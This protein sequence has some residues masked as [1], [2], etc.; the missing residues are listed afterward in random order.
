LHPDLAYNVVML[1]VGAFLVRRFLEQPRRLPWAW[2]AVA[3][4]FGFAAAW[5][6][7]HGLFHLLRLWAELTFV[8]LPAQLTVG[9][10]LARRSRPRQATV[11]LVLAGIV[12]LGGLDAL[13][14][15]P[16]SLRIT[17]IELTS[18]KI[19][20]P[21]RIVVLAD[22]QTDHVGEYE[23]RAIERGFG[24]DPDLVLMPGDYLQVYGP[25]RV[26][27]AT[28]FREMLAELQPSAPLGIWAVGGNVDP[29]D[30][31]TLFEGTEVKTLPVTHTVRVN[32]WLT[33]TGLSLED[34]VNPRLGIPGRRS[35]LHVVFGHAPDF[36]LGGIDADLLLAG[37]THGGQVVLP[38]FGP[39]ITLSR[40][41]RSWASGLT[42]LAHDRHLIVSRGIGME[43]GP[44]P[45]MRFLCRP[46]I[47]VVDI[48]PL[49]TR[50]TT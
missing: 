13:V 27:E 14:I 45:R 43:R 25:R 29:T 47:V 22:L 40:V 1:L 28:A 44:A 36:A 2:I 10:L 12:L 5:P 30:W 35:G 20:V 39:P 48:V 4:V 6:L 17:R 18:A 26:S 42:E 32:D 50:T 38:F 7:S 49:K 9:A 16:H 23:R 19:P 37:H 11:A 21:M 46:E 3:F 41:P 24:L 31:P 8:H 15:E 34:S 33:V